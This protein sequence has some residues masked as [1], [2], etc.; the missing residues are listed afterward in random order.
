MANR[1]K[2]DAETYYHTMARDTGPDGYPIC[3]ACGGT[4][5]SV[6]EILPRSFF[7]PSKKAELFAIEN[8]CCICHDCHETHHNDDGRGRLLYLL[9]S[10]HGYTYTGRAKCLLEEYKERS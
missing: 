10:I 3:V 2:L 1:D 5:T 7:G 4:A 8:R 9:A 6:H